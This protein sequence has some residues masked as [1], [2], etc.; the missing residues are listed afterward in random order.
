MIS[1][2]ET[3]A[4][5]LLPIF[6]VIGTVAAFNSTDDWIW[7]DKSNIWQNLD[8]CAKPC[9]RDVNQKIAIHNTHC[10]SYGC[11]CAE[12]TQGQNFLDGLSNITYC[13]ERSCT[14][15]QKVLDAEIAFQNLCLVYAAN[16]SRPT[17][18]SGMPPIETCVPLSLT[19]AH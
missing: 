19:Y 4:M 5:L 14:V 6:A 12:S 8:I 15:Q 13:A 18:A 16:S 17:T 3:L 10:Q 1:V 11:V 7:V 2:I 9:V